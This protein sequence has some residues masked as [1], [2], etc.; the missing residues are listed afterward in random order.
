MQIFHAEEMNPN[1]RNTMEDCCRVHD[2]SSKS[3]GGDDLAYIGIYDG[4]G[5]R[6]I[7]NYLETALELNILE[8]LHHY[9]EEESLDDY[10]ISDRIKAAF[11]MTDMQSRALGIMNSGATVASVLFKKY[12]D[13]KVT[14]F[15]ANCGDARSVLCKRQCSRHYNKDEKKQDECQHTALRLSH[16]HKAEDPEETK[17]IEQA[18]GFVI[19]GRVLGIL[20]VA[21]SMGDH[22]MKD[23]IIAEPYISVTDL[24]DDSLFVIVACDGL[25]D[26]ITDSEAVDLVLGWKQNAISLQR[27]TKNLANEAI[28]RG[29]TDNITVVIAWF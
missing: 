9:R 28:R 1:R 12:P 25:W 23:F 18:G 3:F 29:S 7:V 24:S 26:V 4:H 21:R 16:D 6:D 10:D 13:G 8:E 17:R 15:S 20:A 5:G 27:I 11:L 19:K 22:S 14:L 2:F